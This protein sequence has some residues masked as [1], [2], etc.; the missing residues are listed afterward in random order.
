MMCFPATASYIGS[1]AST[2]GGMPSSGYV[3]F[4]GDQRRELTGE[5]LRS[6]WRAFREAMAAQWESVFRLPFSSVPIKTVECYE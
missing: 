6:P 5:R 1:V 2:A 4:M 3:G